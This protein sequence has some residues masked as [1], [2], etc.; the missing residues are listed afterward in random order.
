[1]AYL[2]ELSTKLLKRLKD[3]PNVTKEDADDW[4]ERAFVEH[5]FNSDVDVPR[6]QEL[7]ILLYAEWDACLQ[8]AFKAAHYF[9][10]KDSEE[11]VDKRNV[12]EQY[13]QIATELWRVYERKKAEGSGGIGGSRFRVATR[14][15]R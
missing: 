1:M 4:V 9:E 15:D 5:G 6:E 3:V 7:L 2:P 10:Y 13:R 8:I 14:V 12:S 11:T